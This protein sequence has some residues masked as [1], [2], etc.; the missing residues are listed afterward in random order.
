MAVS[1]RNLTP[2]DID[3]VLKQLDAYLANLKQQW[4]QVPLP[5]ASWWSMNRVRLATGVQFLIECLD[6][7]V[8]FVEDLI[9]AGTDKKAA[10]ITL[11]DKLF[12]YVVVQAFPIWLRPFAPAIRE[13]IVNIVISKMIDFIVSKYGKGIWKKDVNNAQKNSR[14]RFRR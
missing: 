3:A 1:K 8:L 14:N 9:P 13:I 12:N 11:L 4:D 10:V 7:L 2:Q 5:A 6:K